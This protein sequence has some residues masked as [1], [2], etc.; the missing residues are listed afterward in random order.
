MPRDFP[1]GH[2]R[3][4]FE[5]QR[6]DAV[7]RAHNARKCHHRTGVAAP[8]LQRRDFY[9]DIEIRSLDAN[10]SSARHR[11]KEGDF[12]AWSD[13]GIPFCVL[14]IHSDT[15]VIGSREN[16]RERAAA[17]AQKLHKLGNGS[18]FRL[19]SRS[20]LRQFQAFAG[21]RQNTEA[22]HC[23]SGVPAGMQFGASLPRARSTRMQMLTCPEIGVAGADRQRGGH[24]QAD[25]CDQAICCGD[26][27]RQPAPSQRIEDHGAD[28]DHLDGRLR[29]GNTR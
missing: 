13:S 27:F 21:P 29:L 4:V 8:L 18:Y 19:A 22:S 20:A 23:L 15:Q 11:R 3:I 16:I 24:P 17:L 5:R 14:L 2:A 26:A 10:A 7:I 25:I 9:G 12:I 28:G 6:F 1:L